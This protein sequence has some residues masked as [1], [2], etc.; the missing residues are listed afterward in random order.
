M[1]RSGDDGVFPIWIWDGELFGG[2]D[3]AFP[4]GVGEVIPPPPT[5]G[6]WAVEVLLDGAVI[7]STVNSA[8]QQSMI[9]D[10][11]QYIGKKTLKF[12]LRRTG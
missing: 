6:I 2:E 5:V 1:P 3:G 11:S 10:V 7:W 4:L 9:F 8:S 12:R